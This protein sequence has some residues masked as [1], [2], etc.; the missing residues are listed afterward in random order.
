MCLSQRIK[1][2]CS[3]PEWPPRVLSGRGL[4]LEARAVRFASIHLP[5]ASEGICVYRWQRNSCV[6]FLHHACQLF[7]RSVVWVN[8]NSYY[9]LLL[10]FS[11]LNSCT[12]CHAFV[13]SCACVH[14]AAVNVL[15]TLCTLEPPYTLC[16]FLTPFSLKLAK[17]LWL[18]S[19][20]KRIPL[21]LPSPSGIWL[22]RGFRINI[23]A[24]ATSI[25]VVFNPY[26]QL[27]WILVIPWALI[28]IYNQLLLCFVNLMQVHNIHYLYQKASVIHVFF[29]AYDCKEQLHHFTSAAIIQFFLAP[30]DWGG[31]MQISEKHNFLHTWG[32]VALQGLLLLNLYFSWR[33]T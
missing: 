21:S 5:A 25:T 19:N 6:A 14:V 1:E 24:T 11:Y 29:L 9:S 8:I 3:A 18:C 33:T 26:R 12:L 32:K 16:S 28:I 22:L 31:R 4:L 17:S 15:L 2:H 30:Y 20:A 27:C 23:S 13:Y 7:S 10:L